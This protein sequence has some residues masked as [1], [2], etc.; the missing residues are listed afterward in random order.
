MYFFCI[1]WG[2][3]AK[4]ATCVRSTVFVDDI[5]MTVLIH[6]FYRL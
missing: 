3:L 6:R 4:V 2:V 5:L 1:I